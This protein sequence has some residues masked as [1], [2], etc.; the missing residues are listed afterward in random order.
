MAFPWVFHANFEAGT[1]AEWDSE[2]DTASQLD[3]PHY[4][5]LARF[6]WPTAAPWQGAY[7]MRAQ[8]TGGT[9]DAF[10][11]EGDIDIADNTSRYFAF[12]IWF[13]P[14]FDATADDTVNVFEAQS[15]GPTVEA[16]FGFRYV[17]STDVI[18]FG[19]GETAPT[20]WG[21]G[22]I[23]KGVWYTVELHVHLDESTNNDGTI[24]LYVTKEGEPYSDDV[25]ASQV[26][27]LNQGAVIQGVFGVQDHL[28]TTTGTILFDQFIMDDAR[29]YPARQR[30]PD[31]VLLTKSSHVFV[32]PGVVDNVTLLS[33][34]G[35]DCVLKIFDTDAADTSDAGNIVVEMNNTASSEMV[36]P[37][38]MPVRVMRGAY[39]ELSGTNPRALVKIKPSIARSSAT[40]RH[41]GLNRNWVR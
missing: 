36:D 28:A 32:G 19:I 31:E 2:T 14:D 10:V 35:T 27:S 25:F 18:N 12:R 9:A 7:C 29:I 15:S 34:A 3:F 40:I 38:G 17:A 20:S 4:S 5:E 33:G 22:T 37:A 30:F 1:N 21:A 6:P 23:E 11:T 41:V 39:V 24:D 26:G 13:S 8:L 16:T